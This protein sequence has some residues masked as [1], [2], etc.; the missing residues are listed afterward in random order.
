MWLESQLACLALAPLTLASAGACNSFEPVCAPP[1][2]VV[3]VNIQFELKFH[4]NFAC[5]ARSLLPTHMAAARAPA[6]APPRA[7]PESTSFKDKLAAEAA[8]ME[9]SGIGDFKFIEAVGKGCN[10]VAF[11][12]EHTR[13]DNPFRLS[14]RYVIKVMMN[15]HGLT[16]RGLRSS[17]EKE[18]S[19]FLELNPACKAL[20]DRGDRDGLVTFHKSFTSRVPED[21]HALLL[22]HYGQDFINLNF[23]PND[24]AC[25]GQ[26]LTRCA[27]VPLDDRTVKLVWF[28]CCC[29]CCCV[30]CVLCV[31]VCVCVWVMCVCCVCVCVVCVSVCMCAADGDAFSMFAVFDAYPLDLK[32]YMARFPGILPPKVLLRLASYVLDGLIFLD[33]HN[34]LHWDVKLDNFMMSSC[35]VAF[36]ADLGEALLRLPVSRRCK[37]RAEQCSGNQVH[38]DPTILNAMKAFSDA[39]VSKIDIDLSGQAVFEAATVI[40][41][42]LLRHLPIRGYP[43]SVCAETPEGMRYIYTRAKI[44]DVTAAEVAALRA[45]GYPDAVLELLRDALEF[46]L[47]KRPPLAVFRDE[48]VKL[49]D[50]VVAASLVAIALENT[51]L[52]EELAACRVREQEKDAQ[53]RAAQTRTVRVFACGCVCVLCVCMLCM[54]V[55]VMVLMWLAFSYC[56]YACVQTTAEARAQ[57]AESDLVRINFSCCLSLPCTH[58]LAHIRTHAHVCMLLSQCVVHVSPVQSHTRALLCAVQLFSEVVFLQASANMRAETAE[59][60]LS[61]LRADLVRLDSG[62]VWFLSGCVTVC[63]QHNNTKHINPRQVQEPEACHD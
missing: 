19:T 11:L 1:A 63:T 53:L 9:L 16:T 20:R 37:L 45:A 3:Y 8:S 41:T 2:A 42:L 35:G 29:C 60:S 54:C 4:A 18:F 33:E 44:C 36:L 55:L 5:V 57:A 62:T 56:C 58:T 28:S 43:D 51:R 27:A 47:S 61:N 34:I 30:L 21:M 24:G 48:L 39:G 17:Y 15:M 38:R 49:L 59:R 14:K 40:G 22:A 10:G 52:T 50:P 26:T 13:E 12:V 25:H 46:D 32:S 31:C 23:R 7:D 6:L